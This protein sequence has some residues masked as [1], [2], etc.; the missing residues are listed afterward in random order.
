MSTVLGYVSLLCR[1]TLVVVFALSVVGKLRSRAAYAGFRDATWRL[2]GLSAERTAALA[3][4]VVAGE[5]T[6]ALTAS[7]GPFCS[8]G[9]GLAGVLLVGFT[10]ALVRSPESGRALECGCFGSVVSATRRT[11]IARNVLLLA[12]VAG[13]IA[14][15]RLR[16]G[17]APLGWDAAL[18]CAV[19][20]V[21]LAVV[22]TRLDEITSLFS[23]RL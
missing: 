17:A 22:I 21:A 9:V 7:A 14:S 2:T 8:A 23:A 12:V 11:A 6:V 18:V 4:L 10:W 16:T 15:T 20:A 1:G 5:V 13:G 3:R 19:G